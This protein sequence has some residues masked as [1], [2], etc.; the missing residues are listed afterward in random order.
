MTVH[1]TLEEPSPSP[2]CFTITT[3]MSLHLCSYAYF[4]SFLL[5]LF[6][7]S[8]TNN[9]FLQLLSLKA[10]KQ[11][12]V[13]ARGRSKSV[14]PSTRL[15]IGFDDEHDL[16]YV[17]PGITT[18]ARAAH[19]TRATPKKVASNVVTASKS[20]EER[21]LT[22]TPSGSATHEEKKSCSLGVCGRRKPPGPQKSLHPLQLHSLPCLMRLTV[23]IP[24]QAHRLVLS[25]WLPTSPIGGV[26]TSNTKCISMPSF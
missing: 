15:V 8:S 9:D 25:P 2:S 26:S 20:I 19:A 1:H 22:S 13:Y 11:D 24:L 4:V 10:Q 18:P 3:E 17:P 21:T 23:L 14:A 16:E 6:A 7:S 5:V 12:R